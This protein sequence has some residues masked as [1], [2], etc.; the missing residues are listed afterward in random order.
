MEK[1]GVDERE[2]SFSIYKNNKVSMYLIITYMVG[3]LDS[4]LLLILQII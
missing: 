3:K 1:F 4:L 2:S